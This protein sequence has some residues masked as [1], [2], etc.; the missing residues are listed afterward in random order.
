[1]SL[2]D[3]LSKEQQEIL[4]ALPYRTGLWVSLSDETGGDEADQAE[5]QAL[6]SI[7]TSYAYDYCK[8]EMVEDLMKLTVAHKDDWA[9]WDED[10]ANVPYENRQAVEWLAGHYDYK[11][12]SS[13]KQTMM[14]IA[15]AVAMA[16]REFDASVSLPVKIK[17]YK[18]LF[19]DRIQAMI[20]RRM[21]TP[22]SEI[23]NISESERLALT[24]L[25]DALKLNEQEGKEPI[26]TYADLEPYIEPPKI[27]ETDI[28]TVTV[29]KEDKAGG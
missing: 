12:I 2:L 27:E 13:F 11:E 23:L 21:P 17:M 6:D 4:I 9:G 16:F 22:T 25:A 10:I 8:S 28:V 7:V 20:Q 3:V 19:A 26:D 29:T 1:M 24:E 18:T 15:T 14:E 5:M